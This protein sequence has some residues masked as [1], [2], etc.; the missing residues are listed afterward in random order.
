MHAGYMKHSLQ[1]LNAMI[2]VVICPTSGFEKFDF[3]KIGQNI[4]YIRHRQSTAL[5]L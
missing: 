1:L 5:G 2:R 4:L 3:E